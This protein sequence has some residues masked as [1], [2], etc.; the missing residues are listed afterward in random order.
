VGRRSTRSAERREEGI[1]LH[2]REGHR[3]HSFSH[4]GCTSSTEGRS[5]STLSAEEREEEALLERKKGTGSTSSSEGKDKRYTHSAEGKS[6]WHFFSRGKVGLN[7]S[8]AEGR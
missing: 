7:T 8:S 2:Q 6:Y 5:Y 1:L 4:R 3:K